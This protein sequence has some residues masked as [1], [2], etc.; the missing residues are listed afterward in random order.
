MHPPIERGGAPAGI[1]QRLEQPAIAWGLPAIQVKHPLF[2][3]QRSQ[4]IFRSYVH[5]D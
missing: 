4:V 2:M 1:R 5:V 3:L